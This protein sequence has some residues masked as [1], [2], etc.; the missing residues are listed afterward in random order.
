MA[1]RVLVVEDDPA[2][3]E[4][5]SIALRQA[6]FETAV[7]GEGTKVMPALRE[8]KPDL[9]LLDLMLPGMSGIDVCKAI[10]AESDVPVVMLTAKSDTVDVVLGLE[11][12]AD[13][14]MVKPPKTQE[15]VARLRARL[16]RIDADPA[17]QLTI[18]D[19][20]IDVPGHRVIRDGTSIS[21][22]P[23]EFE[24]LLALAR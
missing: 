1:T 13:D 19:L 8:L 12:G 5:L 24:L 22:T 2:S 23:L 6:G 4:M 11:S 10:R 15:L 18:G 21:L 3:A 20:E 14:Y 17:E 16:R 9:V 7:V